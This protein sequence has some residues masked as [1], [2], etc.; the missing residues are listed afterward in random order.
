MK[1]MG[2]TISLAKNKDNFLS[3]DG[4]GRSKNTKKIFFA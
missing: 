1:A 2:Y 4:L 3:P